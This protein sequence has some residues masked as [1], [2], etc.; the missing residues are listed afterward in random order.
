M[1]SRAHLYPHNLQSG[2]T[3]VSQEPA[4]NMIPTTARDWVRLNVHPFG[5][6]ADEEAVVDAWQPHPTPPCPSPT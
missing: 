3:E 5:S 6:L 1:A 2:D 4:S